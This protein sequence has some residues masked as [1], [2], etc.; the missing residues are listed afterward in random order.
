M[1]FVLL[2]TRLMEWDWRHRGFPPLAGSHWVTGSEDRLIKLTLKGLHG[3]LE[4]NGKKYT[5]QV[6]MTPFERMLDDEQIAA[7]LTYVRNSFDNESSVISP[8]KVKEIRSVISEKE[9]FYTPEELLIQHP[10]DEKIQ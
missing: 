9:G 8:Q 2:A 4:V 5:G 7:V 1:A 3:P 6:P 10:H